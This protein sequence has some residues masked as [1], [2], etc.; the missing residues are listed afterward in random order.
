MTLIKNEIEPG[1]TRVTTVLQPFSGYGQ[2]P[3]DIL[4]KAAERGTKVHKVLEGFMLGYGLHAN[5]DE[6]KGYVQSALKWWGK[7]Y[8][9]IAMEKR[10]NDEELGITGQCDLIVKTH[11]G[12]ALIDWK[13]SSKENIMWKLQGSAYRNL[14]IEHGYTVDFIW[15]VK[16]SKEGIPA[17][18]FI[19]Q[20]N[21]LEFLF[22]LKCYNRYFKNQKFVNIEDI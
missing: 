22:C 5:D 2:I 8:P 20:Y 16:L 18:Q 3:K 9:I 19:Y 21:L 10:F 12:N 15:F 4:I 11:N 17:E 6:T 14:A 7:G 13:T 1:L